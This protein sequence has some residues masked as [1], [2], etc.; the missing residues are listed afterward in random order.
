MSSYSLSFLPRIFVTGQLPVRVPSSPLHARAPPTPLLAAMPMP[1]SALSLAGPWVSGC[2]GQ[3]TDSG[4]GGTLDPRTL[5]FTCLF[6]NVCVKPKITQYKWPA[7]FSQGSWEDGGLFLVLVLHR[8]GDVELRKGVLAADHALFSPKADCF[9][10][11]AFGSRHRA[12][13]R[14]CGERLPRLPT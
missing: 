5:S 6:G 7:G 1:L 2:Q 10:S 4:E 13:G 9:S 12:L 14:S 3:G 11:P 8:C